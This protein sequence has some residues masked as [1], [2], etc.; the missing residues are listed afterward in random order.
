MF[1]LAVVFICFWFFGLI[2]DFTMGGFIH[3]FLLAAAIIILV[4]VITLVRVISH[5]EALQL[6]ESNLESP[7]P[8][9]SYWEQT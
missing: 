8:Q 2:T 7:E 9:R 1:S 5:R 4:R 3:I 6:E